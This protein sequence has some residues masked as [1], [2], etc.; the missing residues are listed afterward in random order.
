MFR[1]K[2]SKV[3][4]VIMLT[5]ALLLLTGAFPQYVLAGTVV[6]LAAIGALWAYA[7][8]SKKKIGESRDER[9]E[10][11]SM[12]ATHNAFMAMTLLTAIVITAIEAGWLTDAITGLRSIWLLGITAYLLSY[13]TYK[14]FVTA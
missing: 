2:E 10:R 5:F 12:L 11:C 8:L 3:A 1:K 9:S 13:L 7:T 4:A 14:R 6:I